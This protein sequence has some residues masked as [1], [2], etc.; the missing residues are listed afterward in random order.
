MATLRGNFLNLRKKVNDI[1]IPIPALNR[2]VQQGIERTSKT[3][4]GIILQATSLIVG[5]AFDCVRIVEA[6][7]PEDPPEILY[8]TLTDPKQWCM[9]GSLLHNVGVGE[10][11]TVQI[12]GKVTLKF[13]TAGISWPTDRMFFGDILY[14]LTGTGN[15]GCVSNELNPN[16]NEIGIARSLVSESLDGSTQYVECYILPVIQ[17][18][19]TGGGAGNVTV[20]AATTA[21]I[22]L[23]GAKTLDGISC[24]AGDI[25]LV[26]NQTSGQYNGIYTVHSGAS[27]AWIRTDDVLVAGMII[28]VRQGTLNGNRM[29]QLIT[30][31]PI[32]PDTTV[33]TIVTR[34]VPNSSNKGDMMY[35]DGTNWVKLVKGTDGQLLACNS[36]NGVVWLA[37]PATKGD[38]LYYD[39]TSWAKL[40]KGANGKILWTDSSAGAKWDTPYAVYS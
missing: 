19:E 6:A 27:P 31:E 26:K 8:A 14:P 37:T 40:A 13:K 34:D 15:E 17:L 23:S 32:T 28:T 39:G 3:G 12:A 33:L 2:T 29:F 20:K 10:M 4:D 11:A 21:N 36:A 30:E 35:H 1:S 18:T 25:V 9:Y 22:A 24:I 38:L 16:Y 7:N 5:S